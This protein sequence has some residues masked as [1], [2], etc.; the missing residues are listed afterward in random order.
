MTNSESGGARKAAPR[1]ST[2]TRRTAKAASTGNAEPTKATGTAKAPGS[3]KKAPTKQTTA[4]KATAAKAAPTNTAPTNTAPA[5][6]AA[7]TTTATATAP[8]EF[9]VRNPATGEL[10]GVVPVHSADEVAAKVRELR[11]FQPEWEAIGPEGRKEWLLKLQ[12]W[13]VD[14]TDHLADVLQ[15]ETGKARIDSLIDPAFAVDLTGYYARRAAK[16]LAD[17]HPS[18]HSP[19]ARVKTLTTV[20]R[21]YPVVGVITPWNFPLAMPAIDVIP[22]LAAGAAVLLKPSEVTPLSALELARGWEAIG[23]PPVFAI[24]TGA[25][26]TGKAVV[27]NVDYVQFT[28]ST[29]TGRKIAAACT[30]RMIPFSLELGGKDPAIVLADADLDRAAHGIAFGGLFNAG[31]VCISVERVYVEAP[32]YDEFLAK[33]TAAVKEIRQ[34][35]D[36]RVPEYDMGALANENQAQ[37]VQRHV[38]QAVDAGARVL[39]GGKRTGVGTLFEPT[40]LADVDHS[41]TCM[42]EETFGPTLPVMKVSDEAEAVRLANDSIYGLSASV[43]SGDKARAERVARQLNAGAVNI[44]DVFSNM[45]SFA[46]PM[47]GWGLSGVGARWGG[48]N[49]VRKYCRQQAITKPLL[50]TQTKELL[51]FPYSPTKLAIAM[52]AMRAAGSRGM[53]RL[54]VQAVFNTFSG[55]K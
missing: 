9:E 43:W 45:F 23:A 44:N 30:E 11:L 27:D 26:E 54:S 52:S 22:A 55:K 4:A 15:S 48:P 18:P 21:P 16:F 35:V 37:I 41:M 2:G 28:G 50:P 17:E 47:G 49:G 34:G 19:L 33:L 53:R 1:K 6:T 8:T 12:D 36:G 51:W 5:D 13:L 24:V 7:P 39:T 31:Q 46:L 38:Q 42:T 10:A 20:F 3:A 25:G 40:V 29:G 32:V 14:N